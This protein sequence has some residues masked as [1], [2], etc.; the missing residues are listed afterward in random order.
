M[1]TFLDAALG[2]GSQG[3]TQVQT[4]G[5]AWSDI[6]KSQQGCFLEFELAK[7]LRNQTH[8]LGVT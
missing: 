8:G 5:S 6:Q 4:P 7:G 2:P 1:L 3:T